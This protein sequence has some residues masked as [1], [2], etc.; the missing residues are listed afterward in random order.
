[1]SEIGTLSKTMGGEGVGLFVDFRKLRGLER[2][3]SWKSACHTS[4]RI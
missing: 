4:V 2:W 3:L 1:M